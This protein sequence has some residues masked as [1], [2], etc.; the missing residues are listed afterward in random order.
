MEKEAHVRELEFWWE[1]IR[2]T[3]MGED[4]QG[5]RKKKNSKWA[6]GLGG[7]K[8]IQ[9]YLRVIQPQHLTNTTGP[10]IPIIPPS[11]HTHPTLSPPFTQTLHI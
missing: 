7:R 10:L 8:N 2:R 9:I 1:S 4:D 6:N 11:K 3:R 5:K